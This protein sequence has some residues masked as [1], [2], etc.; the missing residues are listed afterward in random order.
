VR[1]FGSSVKVA[2]K[3]HI[4]K[5]PEAVETFKKNLRQSAVRLLPEKKNNL[6]K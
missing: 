3:S 2:R 6:K 1:E 5:D 4:K